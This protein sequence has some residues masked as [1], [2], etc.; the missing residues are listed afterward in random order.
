[1]QLAV[2]LLVCLLCSATSLKEPSRA[3]TVRK[4]L[5]ESRIRDSVIRQPTI[6]PIVHDIRGG[7]SDD[8]AIND[9]ESPTTDKSKMKQC[10]CVLCGQEILAENQADCEAHM[11]V[12]PAFARVHAQDGSTNPDGVYPPGSEPSKDTMPNVEEVQDTKIDQGI[13]SM[14]VKELKRIIT[15]AGLSHADC[16]EKSDLQA[17]AEEALNR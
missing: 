11:A 10:R 16:I 6:L 5:F 9:K 4:E 14:S 17:R 12:C 1:M 13:Y 8:D 2:L 15:N 7:Y 3:F